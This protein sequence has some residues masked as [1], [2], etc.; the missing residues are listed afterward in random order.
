[1]FYWSLPRASWEK[2]FVIFPR[3]CSYTK[4]RIWFEYAYKGTVMITGPGDPV[5]NT[6]W[7]S[8]QSYILLALKGLMNG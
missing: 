3:T 1:M 8:T 6:Y 2:K 5:Y 4:K 7:V